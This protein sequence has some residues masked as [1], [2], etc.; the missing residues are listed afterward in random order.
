MKVP[1]RREAQKARGR[2][3]VEVVAERRSRDV[4]L[5]LDLTRRYPLVAPLDD[6]AQDRQPQR[7]AEGRELLRVAIE[8]G[9][10]VSGSFIEFETCGK[11]SGARGARPLAQH[12]PGV[13]L[14][15]SW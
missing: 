3:A 15:T 9:G 10:H 14:Q 11:S 7:V 13:A 6:E 4:D 2:Q 12:V 5:R 1:S 8:L